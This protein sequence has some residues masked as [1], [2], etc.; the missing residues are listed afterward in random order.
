MS[1]KSIVF[2]LGA[3]VFAL[4]VVR[5]AGRMQGSDPGMMAVVMLFGGTILGVLAIRFILPRLGDAVGAFFYMPGGSTTA[6]E[7]ARGVALME[8][9]DYLGAVTE[10]E[11]ALKENL[12]DL[13][14]I[15]EIAKIR[16]ER[17]NDPGA[18]VSFLETQ[19]A[20]R[21]WRPDDESF[22]RFRVAAIRSELMQD[23]TGAE[24]ALGQ[25]IVK[26]PGTRHSANASHKLKELASLRLL[27]G[28]KPS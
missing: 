27:E 17:L 16:A 23:Y 10:Y 13:P 15:A 24:T 11:K 3:G 18:A 19:L 28:G 21:A 25:V 6:A 8:Q 20:S 2:L 26:F 14:A 4:L 12:G 7:P 9:G 5:L 22:M 1:T